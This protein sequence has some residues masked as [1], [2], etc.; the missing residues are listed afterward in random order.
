MLTRVWSKVIVETSAAITINAQVTEQ[1]KV[2]IAHRKLQLD[3]ALPTVTQ[4]AKH[5]GVNHNT[6]AAVSR[7]SAI[8]LITAT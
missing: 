1:I 7:L 4:L 2:L 3:D 8:K 6:V 5:L